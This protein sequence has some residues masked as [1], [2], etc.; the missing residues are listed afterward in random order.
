MAVVTY[1][2]VAEKTAVRIWKILNYCNL[3]DSIGASW[4]P[5]G[6]FL[7]M[8]NSLIFLKLR[9]RKEV[10]FHKRVESSYVWQHWEMFEGYSLKQS[11]YI[12]L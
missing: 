2:F 9:G 5:T 10:N 6:E 1:D 12:S 8:A 3:H 7:R 11:I 4:C